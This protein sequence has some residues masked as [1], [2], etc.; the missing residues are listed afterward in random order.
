MTFESLYGVPSKARD[1][2]FDA[3]MALFNDL[4]Y[5]LFTPIYV[6]LE[7]KMD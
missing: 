1:S 2:R 3:F 7:R 6:L 4:S 5:G